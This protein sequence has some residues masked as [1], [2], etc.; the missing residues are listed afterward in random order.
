MKNKLDSLF[1]TLTKELQ[2][3]DLPEKISETLSDIVTAVEFNHQLTTAI[4]G[5]LED[6]SDGIFTNLAN[7]VLMRRDSFLDSLKPGIN[8]DTLV[9]LR[10]GPFHAETLFTEDAIAQ[11]ED[12]LRHLEQ[13]SRSDNQERSRPEK[14]DKQSSRYH[15][16]QSKKD[17][18][19]S[20][21]RRFSKKKTHAPSA[22][23]A[24]PSVKSQVTK[25]AKGN[26]KNK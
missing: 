21:W 1:K 2:P 4:S 16:Y 7:S 13:R 10:S 23:Q 9:K 5:A 8:T 20:D 3:Y 6:L 14:Q 11:A 18:N 15:P 25:P 22:S 19:R 26:Q 12:D 24:K 17:G